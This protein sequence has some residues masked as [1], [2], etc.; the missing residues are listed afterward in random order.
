MS[1]VT[2][3]NQVD[4]IDGERVIIDKG[5]DPFETVI[6]HDW[7]DNTTWP[8]TDNSLW[9]LEPSAST[10]ELL[11]PKAEVQFT[12]DVKL[13]SQTTPGELYFDVWVYNPLWDSGTATDPD[14]PTFVPGVSSGNP[15]RFLYERT[16]YKSI[17][18][19]FNYGNKHYTMPVAVDGL[20]YGITTVQFD[21][22]QLIRLSGADGAQLRFSMKNHQAM[23]GEFCTISLIVRE[24]DV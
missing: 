2:A 14:D 11:I 19:V 1:G 4:I 3:G 6:T 24:Q 22:D 16:V 7:T 23:D 12:H 10:K 8:A 20:T 18:D 21:Y 5:K 17:K 13:G 15:R 9:M